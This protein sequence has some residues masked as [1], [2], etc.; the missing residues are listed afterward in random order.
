MYGRTPRIWINWD[1]E[2]SGY[3]ENPDNW[4]SLGNRLHWQ[5]EV[6]K[7]NLQTAVLRYINIYVQIKY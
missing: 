5:L 4:I 3:G 2:P 7:K 1:G 6:G